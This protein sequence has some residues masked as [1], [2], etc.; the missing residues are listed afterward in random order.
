MIVTFNPASVTARSGAPLR[1]IQLANQ[2]AASKNNPMTK[3]STRKP[4]SVLPS[5]AADHARTA[6]CIKIGQESNGRV[7]HTVETDWSSDE[8][9]G[10]TSS[11]HSPPEL[12]KKSAFKYVA[13]N[14]TRAAATRLEYRRTGVA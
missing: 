12:R 5:P 1:I 14:V 7:C 4:G 13:N 3:P 10:T 6:R 8:F 2:N 9:R 11:R